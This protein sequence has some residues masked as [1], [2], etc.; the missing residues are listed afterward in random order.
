MRKIKMKFIIKMILI[1]VVLMGC[2]SEFT[3]RSA[4]NQSFP[5]VRGKT[6]SGN[7]I[8]LPDHFK[9][10]VVL[11][12][13]GFVQ[14]SQF[15][16]DRWLIGLD[17]RGVK[18]KIYEIPTI[19]GFWPSLFKNQIDNGMRKGIPEELWKIV[20]TIY[21]DGEKVQKLF[22]NKNPNNARVILLNEDGK[23]DYFYDR[24]FS[25]SAL[26]NVIEL[27]DTKKHVNQLKPVEPLRNK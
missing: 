26:N 5:S 23:I 11:L 13:L 4:I 8:Q 22:G 9:G 27:V 21:K 20:I 15:D 12:L 17:Q 25:V 14:N 6:L 7:S 19:K 18:I 16:I 3:N 1:S 10:E 24:G 2:S